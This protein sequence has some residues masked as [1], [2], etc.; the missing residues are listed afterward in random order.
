MHFDPP[1]S[2]KKADFWAGMTFNYELVG[3][4]GPVGTAIEIIALWK[5]FAKT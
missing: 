2:G 1:L 5:I 4:V 3:L